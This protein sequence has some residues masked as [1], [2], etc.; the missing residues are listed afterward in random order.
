MR[1]SAIGPWMSRS[2]RGILIVVLG[3]LAWAVL[4]LLVASAS[5]V[6]SERTVA[7]DASNVEAS[8]RTVDLSG[9]AS[10]LARLADSSGRLADLSLS[11]PW[12]VLAKVP[13]VG[14]NV[15]ALGVTASAVRSLST[16]ATPLL[17]R[18]STGPRA[19]SEFSPWPTPPKT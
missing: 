16:A 17:E 12:S 5:L 18:A 4:F 7:Q 14:A 11:F 1:F 15:N 13:F 6:A 3:F 19:V 8:V 2:R 10:G 9:A